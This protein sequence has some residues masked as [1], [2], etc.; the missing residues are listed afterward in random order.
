[1]GADGRRIAAFSMRE[2]NFVGP[3]VTSNVGGRD[4]FFVAIVLP[5]NALEPLLLACWSPPQQFQ[6]IC[7]A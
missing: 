2:R 4:V 1:M 6:S 7:L 5:Q 3:R